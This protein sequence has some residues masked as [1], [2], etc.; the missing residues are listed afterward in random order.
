M[1]LKS[2]SKL[3]LPKKER[4]S[5]KNQCAVSDASNEIMLNRVCNGNSLEFPFK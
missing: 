2:S 5:K 1:E 3:S 4:V